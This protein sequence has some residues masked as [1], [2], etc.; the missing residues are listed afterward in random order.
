[1]SRARIVTVD[2]K[3]FDE[4]LTVGLSQIAPVW[5]DRARTLDRII[6]QVHAAADRA[7]ALVTFG[8]ALLPGYPFWIE[9]TDGGPL[10]VPGFGDSRQ[11][12]VCN[13][14]ASGIDIVPLPPQLSEEAA[15]ALA[16]ALLI[17]IRMK[18]TKALRLGEGS[19]G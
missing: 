13:V 9:R 6:E 14:N 5:L 16:T 3:H 19:G 1:M 7:C 8:E 17:T 18:L 12:L 10:A 4:T 15:R 2:R 11:T